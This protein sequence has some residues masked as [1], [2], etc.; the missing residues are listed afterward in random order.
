[1]TAGSNF[2]ERLPVHKCNMSWRRA[3]APRS[4]RTES[5]VH[6][7]ARKTSARYRAIRAW[8]LNIAAFFERAIR[9]SG[10]DYK[11]IPAVLESRA[12]G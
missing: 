11:M 12:C 8:T 2:G 7:R 1:M 10:E 9:H 6:K 3:D 4:P 5:V